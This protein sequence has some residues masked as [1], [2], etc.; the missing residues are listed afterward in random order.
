[1]LELLSDA[2]MIAIHMQPARKAPPHRECRPDTLPRPRNR[3]L[4]RERAEF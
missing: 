3:W 2:L 1:M 4:A